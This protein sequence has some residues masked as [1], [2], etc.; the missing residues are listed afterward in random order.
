MCTTGAHFLLPRLFK[1]ILQRDPAPTKKVGVCLN[2]ISLLHFANL[3]TGI[4]QIP[5]ESG[6]VNTISYRGIG[7]ATT[8]FWY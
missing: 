6:S 8:L 4:T 5:Y 1:V 7:C 3:K 2:A